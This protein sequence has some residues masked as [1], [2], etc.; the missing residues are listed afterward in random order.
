MRGTILIELDALLDTRLG[1]MRIF[2]ESLWANTWNDPA[3]YNRLVD[4]FEHFGQGTTLMWEGIYNQRGTL[5]DEKGDL[6]VL[7]NSVMSVMVGKMGM[8]LRQLYSKRT[9]EP[10]FK[11]CDVKVNVWPYELDEI[12]K[13]EIVLA[14]EQMM[15]PDESGADVEIIDTQI[16][17]VS[18]P[19]SELTLD[20]IREEY[21]KVVMYNFREWWDIQAKSI[22]DA[23]RGASLTEFIVPELIRLKN[24]QRIDKKTFVDDT[25]A[26]FN[27][28]EETK[29]TLAVSMNLSFWSPLYFSVP[30]PQELIRGLKA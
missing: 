18:I 6:K 8:H 28:F 20:M 29:R 26:P 13:E 1:A 3:Y 2:S 23:V 16:S 30:N 25:G 19:H 21:T 10:N 9:T 4:D 7:R 22:Y 12:D 5:R 14:L 27:P 17:C 15:L 11:G 24:S